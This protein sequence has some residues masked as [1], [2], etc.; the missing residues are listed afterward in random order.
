MGGNFE[1]VSEFKYFKLLLDESDRDGMYCCRK[2]VSVRKIAGTIK[3]LV[4]ARRSRRLE[5]SSI[6]H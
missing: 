4:N 5:C 6:L 3:C 2:V 1:Y